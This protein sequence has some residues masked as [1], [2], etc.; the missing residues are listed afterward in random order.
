MEIS[1]EQAYNGSNIPITINRH[2]IN[3]N[4]IREETETLYIEIP[5]GIDNN[6]I[7]IIENKGN[8]YNEFKSNV[9]VHTLLL[10]HD[11]YTRNGLDIIYNINISFKESLIGF[12]YNFKYLN[13]KIYKIVNKDI[14]NNNSKKIMENLGFMRNNYN[15]NLIIL[16]NVIYPEKLSSEIQETLKKIL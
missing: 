12:E 8:S 3:N 16:F 15:G 6:E 2:I 13:N 10:K 4:L 11:L 7:I 1:F 5:K 9:K 14:L